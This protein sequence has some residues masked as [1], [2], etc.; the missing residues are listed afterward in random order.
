MP[1][2]PGFTDCRFGLQTNTQSWESPLTNDAQTVLLAGSRWI[3]N[4]SLPAMNRAQAANWKSFFDQLEGRANTFYGFDPDCKTPRGFGGGTPLVNGVSQTG[5]SLVTDG[6]PASK[7]VL[8][9]GDYFGVNGE[10]KRVTADCA[11][12]GSGNAT[13]SFKPALRA[14]PGDNS[15]VTTAN[16]TCTMMLADDNQAMFTCNRN[17]VYMPMTFVGIEKIT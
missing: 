4:F 14:S 17:G 11:S 9:A 8:K 12:D 1:S 10:L 15:A 5:S 13:I 16:P 6:W 3:G 7:T 2:Y